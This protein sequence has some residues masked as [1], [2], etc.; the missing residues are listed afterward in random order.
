MSRGVRR[1]VQWA[2]AAAS[3][4]PVS[5]TDRVTPHRTFRDD[6]SRLWNAW[7]VHPAWGER[8]LAERRLR[9]DALPPAVRERRRTE[10]RHA[11]ALRI[12]L[13]PRLAHGWIAFECGEERRRVAPIPDGWSE[14]DES[15]LRDLW[16]AAE[17][18]PPRRKRLVE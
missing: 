14:L 1:A 17:E 12:A 7:D 8:R 16:A 9:A 6:I 13:P 4:P 10:R 18:L 15:G 5:G 3:A 11:S 2:A